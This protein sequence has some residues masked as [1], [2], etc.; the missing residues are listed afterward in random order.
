MGSEAFAAMLND[1]AQGVAVVVAGEPNAVASLFPEEEAIVRKAVDKRRR[2][3]A[4]GRDCARRAL[5]RFGVT[6]APIGSST[7]RAPL[8]P[9]GFVGSITHCEGFTAA[10]VARNVDLRGIGVDAESS[11]PLGSELIRTV[12]TPGEIE[13]VEGATA[14]A[15]GDW[16]K[17]VF[18]AKESVHKCIH[19][20]AGVT[21]DFLEVELTIQ[22]EAGLFRAR[23]VNPAP[24]VG[25]LPDVEGCFAVTQEYVFT[26]AVLR[27][28]TS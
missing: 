10:V 14:P 26:A 20:L 27:A 5:A 4:S 13:W 23:T 18:S 9:L 28:P 17:V 19:P 21:L 24:N 6:P 2:E 22:S 12:L 7:S 11:T 25:H 15:N 8:W 3:F 16:S 1:L